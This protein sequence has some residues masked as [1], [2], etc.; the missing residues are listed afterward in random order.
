M[1]EMKTK[2]LVIAAILA[3][4]AAGWMS[5]PQAASASEIVLKPASLMLAYAPPMQEEADDEIETGE[6]EHELNDAWLG[7]PVMSKD[8]RIVGSVIDAWIGE[9]GEVEELLVGLTQNAGGHAVYVDGTHALLG[10]TEIRVALTASAIA[11]LEREEF[12][13]SLR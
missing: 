9:D 1:Q 3:L 5:A 12:A 7:M 2:S 8:G 4:S 11:A 10:E 13:L 6:Y